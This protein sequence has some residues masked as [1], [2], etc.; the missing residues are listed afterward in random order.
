MDWNTLPLAARIAVCYLAACGLLTACFT[1]EWALNWWEARTMI[2]DNVD[3]HAE[4]P[5]PL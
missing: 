2:H 4:K 1:A 3:E 5:N